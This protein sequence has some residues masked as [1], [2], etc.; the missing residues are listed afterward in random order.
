MIFDESGS[1]S[2]SVAGF[3]YT[4]DKMS[5]G[6]GEELFELFFG[7]KTMFQKFFH[8]KE[9]FNCVDEQLVSFTSNS[10]VLKSFSTNFGDK[11]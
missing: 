6:L 10:L 2:F 9:E 7:E 5:Y 11:T 4:V 3:I 8:T 1:H